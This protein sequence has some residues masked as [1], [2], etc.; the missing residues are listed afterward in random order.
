MIKEERILTIR[1]LQNGFVII[2]CEGDAV[3]EY[4][5]KN[6]SI[7]NKAVKNFLNNKLPVIKD[8]NVEID[9]E[10]EEAEANVTTES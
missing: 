8:K 1:Q 5:A 9:S 4:I 7:V 10:T 3:E 6:K 2:D